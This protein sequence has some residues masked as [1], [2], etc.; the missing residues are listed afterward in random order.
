[1]LIGK[2]GVTITSDP[3]LGTPNTG[4]YLDSS[5]LYLI[6]DGVATVTLN[7][8]TGSATFKGTIT[9]SVITGSTII[10]KNASSNPSGNEKISFVDNAGTERGLIFAGLDSDLRVASTS[11]ML[12]LSGGF[13]YSAGVWKYGT[14]D[15]EMFAGRKAIIIGG[16]D[17]TSPKIV[18]VGSSFHTGQ[19]LEVW[20]TLAVKGTTKSTFAG[21]IIVGAG[22]DYVLTGPDA[23]TALTMRPKTLS[24]SV[25][26]TGNFATNAWT[27]GWDT[28]AQA[29]YFSATMKGIDTAKSTGISNVRV[30]REAGDATVKV[31]FN[32]ATYVSTQTINFDVMAMGPA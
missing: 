3:D 30:T 13:Y 19:T 24:V 20:D 9:A 29:V 7:G 18:S 22:A 16:A 11:S 6:K 27:H 8:I 26:S 23:V 31:Q 10:V 4:L 17:G 12:S 14:Y 21:N 32:V 5:V 1:M 28:S 2:G 25:T 15:I